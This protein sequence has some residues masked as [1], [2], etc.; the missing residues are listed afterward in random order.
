MIISVHIPKTAGTSFARTLWDIYGNKLF[1]DYNDAHIVSTGKFLLARL[2]DLTN[3]TPKKIITANIKCIH[4]HFLPIKYSPYFPKAKYIIWFRD[5]VKR[6]I[7]YYNFIRNTN[8]QNI[9]TNLKNLAAN[10]KLN[11]ETGKGIIN[12]FQKSKATK[13]IFENDLAT[14]II[15]NMKI[16]NHYKKYLR[17]FNFDKFFFVGI[18]EEYDRSLKLFQKMI[19]HPN[20]LMSYRENLN[21]VPNN[22]SRQ[23]DPALSQTIQKYNAYDM[24]LYAR[25]K[26]KFTELCKIYSV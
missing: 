20:D 19:D 13:G 16:N 11:T 1:L 15:K 18:T 6:I 26:E 5:P 25:A 7:S 8:Y 10:N 3:N 4:G 17:F 21:P 23:F 12:F 14:C 22:N 2:K 24:D 9:A